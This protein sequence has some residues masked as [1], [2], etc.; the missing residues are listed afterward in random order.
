MQVWRWQVLQ[1][2]VQQHCRCAGVRG[3]YLAQAWDQVQL[4]S[5][6]ASTLL[7]RVAQRKKNCTHV[8]L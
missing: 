4:G 7:G 2:L 8:S 3:P 5:Q 6:A 1:Q